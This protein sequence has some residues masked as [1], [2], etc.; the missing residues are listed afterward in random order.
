MSD[1][2]GNDNDEEEEESFAELLE[3]Y[4]AGM[5]EDLQVGDRISGEIISVGNDAVFVDT[6]TKIDGV[7]EK[8]E[9][10]DDK[11][12][13]PYKI[14]DALE[15]YVVSVDENRIALSRGLSGTGGLMHL[16]DAARDATPVEGTVREQRKGGFD[17]TVFGRRAFCPISQIDLKYVE[18]PQDYVGKTYMFSITEFEENG[19]NIVVS[20]REVL[21][22]EVEEAG[23]IFYRDVSAGDT[24]KG[25]VT[26]IESYG[27]FVEVAPGIEGMVHVSEISWSKLAK[28]SDILAIGDQVEVLV[29]GIE[30]PDGSN[31]L[32]ISLSLKQISGDPWDR[33][34]G[35]FAAGEKVEGIVTKCMSFGAF[36]EIAPGIEGLI[37]ISEMSY[38][39]RIL[40]PEDVVQ[41]GESVHVV[42]KDTDL[43]R[44]R[45]SLSLRDAEGD[46]WLEVEEK[47]KIGQTVEGTVEKKEK[48]GFFVALSPGITGL[49]PRSKIAESVKPATIERLREGDAVTVLI[50]EIKAKDR[51]MTLAPGDS[52]GTGDW[53]SYAGDTG[54]GL[55]ALGEKLQE[56][57]KSRK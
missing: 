3:S 46:P 40:K 34:E 26:R 20:R 19:R 54:K 39:R 21:R 31:R 36:V 14:G 42:V 12:E 5:N 16:K 22:K 56:A 2:P 18:N 43:E 23:R 51:R 1:F 33:L 47:Y 25:A 4:S 15:L 45:I 38:T 30:K 50:E 8:A 41:E 9:L 24:L 44:R 13:V 32:K 27:A 52:A 29:L 7:V 17:V 55:G 53:R 11:G 35:R 37:H 48:F 10:L 6:G 49:L 28:P 57:L